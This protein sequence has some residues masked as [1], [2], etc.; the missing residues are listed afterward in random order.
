MLNSGH[1]MVEI[2]K[3]ALEEE[4]TEAHLKEISVIISGG[5]T[6]HDIERA[7]YDNGVVTLYTLTH[8]IHV[9]EQDMI[10][11]ITP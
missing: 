10:A 3:E 1:R 8:R 2:L 6:Y 4:E 7:Q 9:R 5:K 11:I